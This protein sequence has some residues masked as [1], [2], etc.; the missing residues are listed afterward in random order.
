MAGRRRGRPGRRV[1]DDVIRS[2][3][4]RPVVANRKID[5]PTKDAA[6]H[7]IRR[8]AKLAVDLS[9]RWARE[10]VPHDVVV[11]SLAAI[12]VSSGD[13]EAISK[14]LVAL[15]SAP[16]VAVSV[17]AIV[18]RIVE[19]GPEFVPAIKRAAV[20]ANPPPV[21]GLDLVAGREAI[22]ELI[23]SSRLR[24]FAALGG[25]VPRFELVADGL[26]P[27]CR[28]RVDEPGTWV[29]GVLAESAD[30]LLLDLLIVNTTL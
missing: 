18:L 2:D 16:L 17:I 30:E 10:L 15:E 6:A 13:R 1:G 26:A 25:D 22:L 14:L 8:A 5:A 29:F 4:P 11:G 27:R 24:A 28:L 20:L 7:A 19:N 3:A 12:V 23:P 9:A 21:D